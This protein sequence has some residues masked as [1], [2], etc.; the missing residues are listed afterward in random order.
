MAHS[1]RGVTQHPFIVNLVSGKKV[2]DIGE[3]PVD[4]FSHLYDRKVV[5]GD[6]SV[7]VLPQLKVIREPKK[8]TAPLPL[9]SHTDISASTSAIYVNPASEDVLPTILNPKNTEGTRPTPFSRVRKPNHRGVKSVVTVGYSKKRKHTEK[10]SSDYLEAMLHRPN[11]TAF[12]SHNPRAFRST[13]KEHILNMS[14]RGVC[15][16]DFCK[17]YQGTQEVEFDSS[18]DCGNESLN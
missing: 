18:T 17:A 8:P 15:S 10:P 6:S 11:Y 12:E 5:E 2:I 14:N 13:A 7:T 9:K 4:G 16:P 1:I 3:H